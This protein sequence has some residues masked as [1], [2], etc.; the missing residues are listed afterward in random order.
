MDEA[1][2]LAASDGGPLALYVVHRHGRPRGQRGQRA[3]GCVG[4]F[5]EAA[6]LAQPRAGD[7]LRVAPAVRLRGG[8][9]AGGVD[10]VKIPQRRAG[11]VVIQYRLAGEALFGHGLRAALAHAHA[12]AAAPEGDLKEASGARHP[13]GLVVGVVDVQLVPVLDRAVGGHADV[14]QR[15]RRL[16]LGVFAG[17]GEREG[18]RSVQ[19]AGL[20]EA[21]GFGHDVLDGGDGHAR[22]IGV[23]PLFPELGSHALQQRLRQLGVQRGGV[24]G[25]GG[26][27]FQ[28]LALQVIGVV[29]D[30][31]VGQRHAQ[32][33]GGGLGLAAVGLAEVAGGEVL[34]PAQRLAPGLVHGADGVGVLRGIVVAPEDEGVAGVG[35]VVGRAAAGELLAKGVAPGDDGLRLQ[36]LQVAG[37]GH[38][39]AHDAVEIVLDVDA[40]HGGDHVRRGGEQ[41][42]AAEPVGEAGGDAHRAALAGRVPGELGRGPQVVALAVHRPQDDFGRRAQAGQPDPQHAVR[43]RMGPRAGQEHKQR[44]R[45]AKRARAGV[46]DPTMKPRSH[47][48]PRSAFVSAGPDAARQNAILYIFCFPAGFPA[49]KQFCENIETLLSDIN[50]GKTK[51]PPKRDFC[52]SD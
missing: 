5:V 13:D 6:L 42:V 39:A 20:G 41:Q 1:D 23:Q 31:G 34:A 26:G 22:G 28:P 3:A 46:D 30:L 8:L 51:I 19:A 14:H 40:Q 44:Q 4:L 32:G 29:H 2:Q 45:D 21:G 50:A 15:V 10:Q 18:Q 7:G 47:E 38:L 12:R 36:R 48:S 43:L 11:V 16:A 35:Q 52:V 33:V 25:Q 9:G 49:V 37:G 27:L 17:D 24:P